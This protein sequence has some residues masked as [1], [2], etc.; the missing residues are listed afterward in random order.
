MGRFLDMIRGNTPDGTQSNKL[1]VAAK[2]AKYAKEVNRAPR[3]IKVSSNVIYGK[4]GPN[5]KK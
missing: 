5:S 1:S 2:E 4:F 3:T